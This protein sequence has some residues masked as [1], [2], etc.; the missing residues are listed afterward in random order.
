MNVIEPDRSAPRRGG[1][2]LLQLR[3]GRTARTRPRAIGAYVSDPAH[4]SVIWKV[5]HLGLSNYTARFTRM[6]AELN[7]NAEHPETSSVAA[8]IDPLSVQTNFPFPERED[9][10]KEIGTEDRFLAGKP[11]SFVSKEI[12]VID[13]HHGTVAGDLTFRGET[14]PAVLNVT[15]NG[16]M[17]RQ[18]AVDTPKIGFSAQMTFKRSD[19]GLAPKIKS[20]GDLVTVLI[21]TE[22]QPPQAADGPHEATPAK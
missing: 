14:H 12:K 19:W 16:S 1:H 17:A 6:T 18:P 21:E 10:D 4:S 2:I 20:I 22:L 13:P 11:I 3:L 8:T 9:F 5:N 7:W 15:F